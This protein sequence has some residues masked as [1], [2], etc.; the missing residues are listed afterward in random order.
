MK[1]KRSKRWSHLCIR[2]MSQ[3]FGHLYWSHLPRCST[4]C[5]LLIKKRNPFQGSGVTMR[6]PTSKNVRRNALNVTKMAPTIN[7]CLFQDA[8]VDA[9]VSK[10]PSPSAIFDLRPL[11]CFKRL[12]LGFTQLLINWTSCVGSSL[13]V[14]TIKIWIHQHHTCTMT[15]VCVL[16]FPWKITI[17]NRILPYIWYLFSKVVSTRIARDMIIIVSHRRY[18]NLSYLRQM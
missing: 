15:M 6:S 11:L 10:Y 4:T 18:Q 14:G 3:L 9:F 12:I 2:R 7:T 8:F 13:S 5:Q 16:V 17:Y 1:G